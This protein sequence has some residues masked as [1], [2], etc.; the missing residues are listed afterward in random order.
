MKIYMT[1]SADFC[2]KKNLKVNEM[3]LNNFPAKN[4]KQTIIASLSS[5]LEF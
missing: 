5:D 1:E 2:S 4:V 3:S